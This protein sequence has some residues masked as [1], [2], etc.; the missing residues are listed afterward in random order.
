MKK[1]IKKDPPEDIPAWFMT[2]SDVITLLMTFFILLLTFATTDPERYCRVTMNFFGSDAAVGVAGNP[3]EGV[4][5]DSWSQRIRPRA[6]QIAM[7]G[8]EMPPIEIMPSSAGL[9]LEAAN[10]KQSQQDVMRSFSFEVPVGQFVNESQNLTEKGQ[11]LA[12]KLS[13]QLRALPVHCNIEFS[14]RSLAGRATAVAD[15]FY[16]VQNTRPGQLGVG[17][18]DD[19]ESGALRFVIERY[20]Q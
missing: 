5:K 7:S 4:E 12:T 15:H 19:V 3:Y 2:Y 14:N 10:E 17:Y 20:E 16:H 9:G 11:Q 18:S 13:N 1:E 8:S 6:A